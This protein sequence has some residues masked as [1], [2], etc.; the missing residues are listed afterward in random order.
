MPDL[1]PIKSPPKSQSPSSRPQSAR[2]RRSSSGSR[3]HISRIFTA[4]HIDDISTYHGGDH[5]ASS[6]DES[7]ESEEA[8]VSEYAE[9]AREED[10]EEAERAGEDEVDTV[11]MGIRGT[12]DLECGADLEKKK[13]TRSL[14]STKS[15]RDPNLV[16][17]TTATSPT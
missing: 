14:K 7:D 15:T 13:T 6:G 1:E 10:A 5:D 8:E 9:K 11:Q 2:A 3:P 12:R 16:C 4:T 17:G